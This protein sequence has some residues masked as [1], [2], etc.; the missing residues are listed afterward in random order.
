MSASPSFNVFPYQQVAYA[1]AARTATPTAFTAFNR[2]G[3]NTLQVLINTSAVTSTPST[4]F[5]VDTWDSKA[6]V[7]LNLLT[8]AAVSAT[9]QLVLQV[10]GAG[11][12]VSNVVDLRHPGRRVRVTPTHGNSN[13]HTYTV[14]LSW[15]RS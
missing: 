2:G 13:S 8:S 3:F 9:G 4:T 11:A 15:L 5:A 6:G 10:G 14:T 1:S 7:W 12:N